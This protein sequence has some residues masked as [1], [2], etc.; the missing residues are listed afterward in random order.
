MM[1]LKDLLI[2][3]KTPITIYRVEDNSG[4][5]PFRQEVANKIKS[6]SKE[7]YTLYKKMYNRISKVHKAVIV[8]VP[9]GYVFG[10]ESKKQ[11]M[12]W[13]TNEDLRLLK[14]YN[15]AIQSYNNVVNYYFIMDRELIFKKPK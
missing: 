4:L 6:S 14:K 8:N 15:F 1:R 10:Y 7:D 3:S 11:L 9:K 13:F 2:E 5:G 12:K